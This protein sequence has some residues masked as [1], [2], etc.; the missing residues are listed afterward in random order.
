VKHNDFA[1]FIEAV[2]AMTEEEKQG[3]TVWEDEGIV[4][5]DNADD[6]RIFQADV[7]NFVHVFFILLGIAVSQDNI[8]IK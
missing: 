1:G 7:V 8:S 5:V 2:K 3:L 6:E 4:R